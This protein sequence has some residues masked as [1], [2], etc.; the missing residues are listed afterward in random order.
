LGHLLHFFQL[1]ALPCEC[2]QALTSRFHGIVIV[3][4]L[5]LH[6]TSPCHI[7]L[8]SKFPFFDI[9]NLTLLIPD[10]HFRLF[11][12]TLRQ[13]RVSPRFS[14]APQ[15]PIRCVVLNL[16]LEREKRLRY[17]TSK[18]MQILKQTGPVRR[19]CIDSSSR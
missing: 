15:T 7:L 4:V 12:T 13:L 16:K 5:V 17:F 6:S 10:H 2:T 19:G 1:A 9:R 14:E 8:A 18:D 11:S 3:L